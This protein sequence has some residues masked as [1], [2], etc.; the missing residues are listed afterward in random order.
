MKLEKEHLPALYRESSEAS[1]GAQKY[2]VLLFKLE[3]ILLVLTSGAGSLSFVD[4]GN[5]K[6]VAVLTAIFLILS[7]CII[8]IIKL[9]GLEKKWYNGR[10]VAESIKTLSWRYVSGS[11]PYVIGL[12][13]EETDS[14]FILDLT[15]VTNER[16]DFVNLFSNE[17]FGA[18]PQITKKMRSMRGETTQIRLRNYIEG[19][20]SDQR[21]WYSGKATANASSSRNL[22]SAVIAFNVLAI[23]ISIFFILKPDILFN[24]TSTFA[25]IA[26]S[27][28]A[29]LQLKK[30]QELAQ[31]YSVAAH[32]L[33]LIEEGAAYIDD[34]D[35]LSTFVAD[36]ENAISREHTLWMARRDILTFRV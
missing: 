24:P 16:S 5:K 8:V 33:G 35:K 34:D 4:V 2:Y 28:I 7:L 31:S 21:Q 13:G 1:Q 25:T 36:S 22:F 3:L 26:A 32:E 20:I 27:L 17:T 6:I 15:N 19:R 30:H 23:I 11:E 10:A 14:K 12:S 9:S 29:W 18:E